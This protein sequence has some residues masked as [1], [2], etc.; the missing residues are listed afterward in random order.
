MDSKVFTLGLRTIAS[1]MPY[2][3]KLEDDEA[4]FLWLTLDDRLKT[5]ISNEMWTYAVKRY[6]DLSYRDPDTPVHMAV[7]NPFIKRRDNVA[8]LEW[9]LRCT[10]G[11]FLRALE[12]HQ[13]DSRLCP[14]EAAS[15]MHQ[16]R[17]LGASR[18]EV[19]ALPFAPPPEPEQT[20]P[21]AVNAHMPIVQIYKPDPSSPT[22]SSLS[23]QELEQR[24][25]EQIEKF[26]EAQQ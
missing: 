20:R 10:P 16:E 2:A 12:A 11:D 13:T 19:A 18:G 4:Q 25:Q 6:L 3:K 22:V 23:R 17:L 26:R 7:L 14:I 5:G 15:Q 1:V 9:G 21:K 24:K 8:W